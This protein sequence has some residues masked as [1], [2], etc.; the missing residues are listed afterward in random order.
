MLRT[1]TILL[2]IAVAI[3]AR[4]VHVPHR[5]KQNNPF[6]MTEG[7]YYVEETEASPTEEE[8]TFKSLSIATVTLGL[9]SDDIVMT[10]PEGDTF[11]DGMPARTTEEPLPESVIKQLE[12]EREQEAKKDA[13]EGQ[14]MESNNEA[15]EPPTTTQTTKITEK[16]FKFGGTTLPSFFTT[17][18]TTVA[19]TKN[20][21]ETTTATSDIKETTQFPEK[22]Q[23]I[24]NFFERK[25]GV[26]EG[27]LMM[28]ENR[29]ATTTDAVKDITILPNDLSFFMTTLA[30]LVDDPTPL[31]EAQKE[32]VLETTLTPLFRLAYNAEATTVPPEIKEEKATTVPSEQDT[33]GGLNG[34]FLND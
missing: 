12:M 16:R 13:P 34:K 25:E 5:V 7:Y 30:N 14:E 18:T 24:R 29:M 21:Q 31:N 23:T 4:S 26:A 15:T 28:A 2:L 20:P 10:S 9:E 3:H 27:D 33:T 8:S 32:H 11:T 19:T 1:I 17:T 22:D 6:P